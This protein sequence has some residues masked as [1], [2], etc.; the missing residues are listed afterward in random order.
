MYFRFCLCTAPFR[1]ISALYDFRTY[2]LYFF[3]FAV[4][5]PICEGGIVRWT[6]ATSSPLWLFLI[7]TS[8]HLCLWAST[9]NIM[10]LRF[11]RTHSFCFSRYIYKQLQN[12]YG[13]KLISYY[14]LNFIKWKYLIFIIKLILKIKKCHDS[15]TN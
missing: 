14:W 4:I 11:M 1:E 3:L 8:T 10:H 9:T 15:I 5:H 6:L 13:V 12:L 2:F 7:F